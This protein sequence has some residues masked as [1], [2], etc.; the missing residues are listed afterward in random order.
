M[1]CGVKYTLGYKCVRSQ[2]YQMP[3]DDRD[4]ASQKVK[5]FTNC[6]DNLDGILEEVE[7]L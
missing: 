1:W 7:D 4:E 3:I 2:L 5:E 6:V